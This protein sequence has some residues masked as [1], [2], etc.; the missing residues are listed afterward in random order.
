MEWNRR[1]ALRPKVL[2]LIT[3]SEVGGAQRVVFELIRGL[4]REFTFALA[5]APG[6]ELLQWVQMAAPEVA[7]YPMPELERNI[8]PG[9]DLRALMAIRRLL[10]R[11]RFDVLHCHSSKAGVLGRLA[12]RTA[13][14]PVVMYTVHG[15]GT[16][17]PGAPGGGS[18]LIAGVEAL[19]S[20][21]TDYLV[22][23]SRADARRAEELGMAP[24]RAGV[25]IRNALPAPANPAAGSDL[26]RELGLAPET[27]L[28]GTAC[29]LKPPK[30]LAMLLDTADRLRDLEQLHWVIV[31]FGP[32]EAEARATARRLGL[33]ERIHFLGRREA[34]P[35]IAD[36]DICV[37]FSRWE[38]LPMSVL[39]AMQAGV[40]VV[41]TRV[42]GMAEL[43]ADG[44][45]GRLVS[46]GDAAAAAAALRRLAT[47][48]ALRTEMGQAGR[49][50]ADQEFRVETMLAEY[51]RLYRTAVRETEGK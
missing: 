19:A 48:S 36:L 9:Q 10:C 20:R 44:G 31:G 34:A 13:Q 50:T 6:G 8:H 5:C 14:V 28:A 41:A 23:V 2:Q 30:D 38:G 46:P 42:G 29:R 24:R 11:E 18:R 39:E 27:V 22:Y 45:S 26:R 4:R 16:N 51:A 33:A 17:A 47:D 12:A 21:W 7:V 25:V 37:L 32:L 3:L 1:L 35:V 40:P 49:R 15:W 43:V